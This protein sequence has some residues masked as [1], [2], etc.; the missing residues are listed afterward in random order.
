M[1]MNESNHHLICS[2][3]AENSA[4]SEK[5][6]YKV[7]LTGGPCGGKTTCQSR[8]STFFENLGWK[9][10]RIPE[11]AYVFLSGGLK[12][13][14][15]PASGAYEFQKNLLRCML[16]VEQTFVDLA[17]ID[18][19]KNIL[20][21]C[22]RGCMDATA[23]LQPGEWDQLSKEMNWNE[24]DLRDR[25]YNQVIHIM[26]AAKGAEAFYTC[27][28]HGTRSE[29]IGL[30]RH[31]DD[32][33]AQAWVGHPYYDV[34]DNSTGFEEK[35]KRTIQSVCERIGVDVKDRLA[36]MSKKRKFL[37]SSLPED[38]KFP[39]N[40]REFDVVHHYLVTPNSKNQARIRKRGT[41]GSSTYFYTVRRPDFEDIE[42]KR[43]ITFRDYEIFLRQADDSHQPIHKKRRAFLWN[44]QYYQLDIYIEPC[45]EAC[46]GLIFLETYTTKEGNSLQIPPFLDVTGEVTGDSKYSMFNLSLHEPCVSNGSIKH[47]MTNGVNGFSEECASRFG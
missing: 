6:I 4:E 21:I 22:D 18:P 26:T 29:G 23:Y 30:A 33:V 28:G 27:E 5:N 11:I 20:I 38:E 37:V 13:S 25:R 39:S 34:I 35:V 16:Q 17:K 2:E 31:L 15:L 41:N 1:E 36:P 44:H 46:K 9:V 32:L 12:F 19:H 45:P 7:V 10:F 3:G 40:F 42:L 24:V 14:D 43:Q 47:A 8:L